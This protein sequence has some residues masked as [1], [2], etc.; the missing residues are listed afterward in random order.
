M[1]G[2][3]VLVF[4]LLYLAAALYVLAGGPGIADQII[5]VILFSFGILFIGVSAIIDALRGRI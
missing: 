1:R 4:G 5:G 2:I 3:V